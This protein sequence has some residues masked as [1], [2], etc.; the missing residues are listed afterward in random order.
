MNTTKLLATWE[1]TRPHTMVGTFVAVMVLW[2]L[3]TD[4]NASFVGITVH[5]FIITEIAALLIN[6]YIV[7]V[8]QIYDVEIDK[9]NKPYLPLASGILSMK[10]GKMIVSGSAVISLTIAWTS[11]FV[12]GLTI[13]LAFIIGT[14]YSVPPIRLKNHGVLS[15]LSIMLVRSFIVNLGVYAFFETKLHH[16]IK[17]EPEIWFLVLFTFAFSLSIAITK[18]V[19]DLSGDLAFDI[20]TIPAM[21][22]SKKTLAFSKTFLLSSFLIGLFFGILFLEQ[23]SQLL[24]IGGNTVLLAYLIK[25]IRDL[26]HR[27][28]K[29]VKA[30][31]RMI[32][33]LFYA[34]YILM[35]LQMLVQLK[36]N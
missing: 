2:I 20:E 25:R 5:W 19:P 32:W 23:A 6:V 18:D 16:S 34:E 11:G 8:N 36:L 17:F 10:E 9:I 14:M 22:G 12:L 15:S 29:E 35:A 26:N 31:Y 7:G 4:L 28:E 1:F 21:I 27:H 3:A 30:F 33:R 24:F 13:S